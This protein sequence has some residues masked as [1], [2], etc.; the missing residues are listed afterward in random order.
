MLQVAASRNRAATTPSR[1]REERPYDCHRLDARGAD[2]RRR[3]GV[4]LQPAIRICSPS[5]RPPRIS[6]PVSD[7]LRGQLRSTRCHCGSHVQIVTARFAASGAGPT[8]R[9]RSKR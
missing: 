1:D 2:V 6:C 8:R 7:M 3:G 4:I 9:H 5:P